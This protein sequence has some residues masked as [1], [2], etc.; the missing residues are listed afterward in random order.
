MGSDVFSRK[1]G[2]HNVIVPQHRSCPVCVSAKRSQLHAANLAH[3]PR[4][5]FEQQLDVR[6]DSTGMAS[7]PCVL[8]VDAPKPVRSFMKAPE[9]MSRHV[10]QGSASDAM[11]IAAS[12]LL[13]DVRWKVNFKSSYLAVAYSKLEPTVQALFMALDTTTDPKLLRMR[14]EY[15]QGMA[16]LPSEQERLQGNLAIDMWHE[17]VRVTNSTDADG[18]IHRF[19]GQFVAH[20]KLL[21]GNGQRLIVDEAASTPAKYVLNFPSTNGALDLNQTT[22]DLLYRLDKYE[23]ELGRLRVDHEKYIAQFTLG[24]VPYYNALN[25]MATSLFARL[26][27]KDTLSYSDKVHSQF[28]DTVKQLYKDGQRLTEVQVPVPVT[29]P[30]IKPARLP[31]Y[32]LTLQS[33]NWHGHYEL[34]QETQEV[35][36]ILEF[37]IPEVYQKW[38]ALCECVHKATTTVNSMAYT[39]WDDLVK[40]HELRELKG[41]MRV[42][43]DFVARFKYLYKTGVGQRIVIEETPAQPERKRSYADD[44]YDFLMTSNKELYHRQ[45]LVETKLEA[46]HSQT[47]AFIVAAFRDFARDACDFYV[48][49]KMPN[50]NVLDT[51][52]VYTLQ[53]ILADAYLEGKRR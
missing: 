50:Y 12:K 24:I 11:A 7:G 28:V 37:G 1:C 40:Q 32:K 27:T 43:Q 3:M 25:H 15:Q 23:G 14:E 16:K 9:S 35:F 34:L 21:H 22:R 20:F 53:T 48:M 45:C 30:A 39:L 8:G 46:C 10:I 4:Y 49:Q 19:M 33:R 42:R 6:V 29:V 36:R 31:T 44:V 18:E 26:T 5:L 17:I 2:A 51:G 52:S 38:Y 47:R 41:H 13:C